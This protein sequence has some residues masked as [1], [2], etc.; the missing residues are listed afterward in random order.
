MSNICVVGVYV[1]DLAAA[2][3]FYCDVLG[4]E[5]EQEFGDCIVQLKNNGVPF[6]LQ[7][8]ENGYPENTTHVLNISVGNLMDR[9][10]EL[11]GKGVEFLHSEPQACPVGIYAGL[12]DPEGNLLELLEFQGA[13]Q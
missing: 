4:F 6:I 11:R 12:K 2:K 10:K 1:N 13:P 3:Q 5:V 9:M 7:K 8:I